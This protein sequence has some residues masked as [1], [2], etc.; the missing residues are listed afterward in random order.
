MGSR[1]KW[2]PAIS[3]WSDEIRLILRSRKLD[4]IN[5]L[6]ETKWISMNTTIID[7]DIQYSSNLKI[8]E[9]INHVRLF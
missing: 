7:Y 3:I 8:I 4:L 9:A 2:C 5:R 6:N 1:L